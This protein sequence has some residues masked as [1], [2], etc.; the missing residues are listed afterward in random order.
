MP[1]LVG[2]WSILAYSESPRLS[3][4]KQAIRTTSL[5]PGA[6]ARNGQMH[7]Y[8]YLTVQP[9]VYG[10]GDPFGETGDCFELFK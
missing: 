5:T 3:C 10:A 7:D 4:V 1:D 6:Q 9:G 2:K 8:E